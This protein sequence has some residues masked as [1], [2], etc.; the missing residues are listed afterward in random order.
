MGRLSPD[1]G[2]AFVSGHSKFSEAVNDERAELATDDRTDD[3]RDVLRDDDGAV[4]AAASSA[5]ALM[6][7]VT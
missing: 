2:S 5:L 6:A 1:S 7:P 3:D 4:S